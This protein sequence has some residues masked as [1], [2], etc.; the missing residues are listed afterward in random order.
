MNANATISKF[1]QLVEIKDFRYDNDCSDIDYAELASD[2]DSKTISVID[3]IQ[4]IS[5]SISA[6][7]DGDQ[8]DNEN[9]R[10][11]SGIIHDLADLAIATNKIS[12]AA[13]YLSG[14]RDGNHGA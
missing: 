13:S 1:F 9:L 2:C 8:P 7:T 12:Q 5:H 6:L 10:H 4:H 3:A 14:V 11:L